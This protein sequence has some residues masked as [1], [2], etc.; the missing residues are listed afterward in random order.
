MY[1]DLN[2]VDYLSFSS[3]FYTSKDRGKELK[4]IKVIIRC[5]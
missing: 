4:V 1:I 5:C 3:Y 2:R